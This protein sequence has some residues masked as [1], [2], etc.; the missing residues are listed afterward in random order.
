MEGDPVQGWHGGDSSE[1]HVL[2]TPR[3]GIWQQ[4]SG[5]SRSGW[6]RRAR[7]PRP[8]NRLPQRP[9]SHIAR[10]TA[11]IGSP[12]RGSRTPEELGF[13]ALSDDSVARA[14]SL[15]TPDQSVQQA[16]YQVMRMPLGMAQSRGG[17]AALPRRATPPPLLQHLAAHFMPPG[18][19]AREVQR[20][21]PAHYSASRLLTRDSHRFDPRVRALLSDLWCVT[22]PAMGAPQGVPGHPTCFV[23]PDHAA[24]WMPACCLRALACSLDEQSPE[25][26]T[27]VSKRAYTDFLARCAAAVI[28]RSIGPDWQDT[29]E[30]RKAVVASLRLEAE[31]DWAEDSQRR[32]APGPPSGPARRQAPGEMSRLSFQVRCPL[33]QFPLPSPL[34]TRAASLPCSTRCFS[35]RTHGRRAAT[36]P[37]TA[38]SS[39]GCARACRC[40]ER[41]AAR[42]CVRC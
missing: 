14:G 5:S 30:A 15:P 40:A 7:E 11:A 38:P 18:L 24:P 33:L 9:A 37:S 27:G 28:G 32:P 13:A 35:W 22:A 12:R 29:D 39:R 4:Q 36:S 23:S 2:R 19:S 6:P 16:L 20:L 26:A 25:Q 31:R 21:D 17:A 1:E 42:R 8:R 10:R 3:G 34:H 41:A